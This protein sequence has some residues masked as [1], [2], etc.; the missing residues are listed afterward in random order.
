MISTVTEYVQKDPQLALYAEHMNM[1]MIENDSTLAEFK[2]SISQK[3]KKT[4]SPFTYFVGK[5]RLIDA[6]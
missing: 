1:L 2:L 3:Y 6:R 5:S 4:P